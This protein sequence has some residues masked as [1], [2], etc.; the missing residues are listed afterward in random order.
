MKKEKDD[1]IV[2]YNNY[3][4]GISISSYDVRLLFDITP[5]FWYTSTLLYFVL[6]SRFLNVICLTLHFLLG[7]TF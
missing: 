3:Y 5:L 2:F 4:H 6:S 1:F 7:L